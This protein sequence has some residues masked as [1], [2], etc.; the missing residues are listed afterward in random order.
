MPSNYERA[1]SIMDD[2][3]RFTQEWMLRANAFAML[4]LVD[5]MREARG[6]TPAVLRAGTEVFPRNLIPGE[7]IVRPR[8]AEGGIIEQAP[9]YDGLSD[10]GVALRPD[11]V[12][13]C[14]GRCCTPGPATSFPGIPWEDEG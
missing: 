11:S 5:E 4:A 9:S 2:G 14:P 8:F 3:G 12:P 6:A 1:L 10:G 13:G 7:K